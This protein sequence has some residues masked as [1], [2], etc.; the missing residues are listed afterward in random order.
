MW[1]TSII[2]MCPFSQRVRNYLAI[3]VTEDIDATILPIQIAAQNFFSPSSKSRVSPLKRQFCSDSNHYEIYFAR[4]WNT[5]CIRSSWNVYW[6]I[7]FLYFTLECRPSLFYFKYLICI[8]WHKMIWLK[9][10]CKRINYQKNIQLKSNYHYFKL[11]SNI[12][13]IIIF[14]I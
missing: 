3:A 6:R 14:F 1:K 2:F 11:V 13:E 7:I 9:S 10:L 12:N 5:F 4:S 8:I